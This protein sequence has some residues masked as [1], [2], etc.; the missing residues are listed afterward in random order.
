MLRQF[1]DEIVQIRKN[2]LSFLWVFFQRTQLQIATVAQQP[3]DYARNVTMV[4]HQIFCRHGKTQQ[5]LAV[6][7]GTHLFILVYGQAVQMLNARML[8]RTP[9]FGG[10]LTFVSILLFSLAVLV[11]ICG[12]MSFNTLADSL[13]NVRFLR[14]PYGATLARRRQ[15]ICG[16]FGFVKFRRRFNFFANSARL[17]IRNYLDRSSH[18]CNSLL[19]LF[20]ASVSD[21]ILTTALATSALMSINGTFGFGKLV[22]R[23]N[24]SA[25]RTSLLQYYNF[26]AIGELVFSHTNV[27]P[28][29]ATGFIT[30]INSKFSN[31]FCFS[32]LGASFS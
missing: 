7:F 3:S 4:N 22:N 32:T 26:I 25:L 2:A 10:L 28:R 9:A 5:T 15:S 21:A 14:V 13:F 16:I 8:N 20:T 12:S 17:A 6:L 24:L 18:F 31:R 30:F 27:T 1:D 23:Q 19:A 29:A 11:H